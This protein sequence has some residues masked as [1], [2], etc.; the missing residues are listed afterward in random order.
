MGRPKGFIWWWQPKG[1]NVDLLAQV[2]DV[3]DQYDEHLPLTLRQIFYRLVALYA[4]EKTELAYKRL[5]DLLSN[6]RRARV[7]DMDA[8]RDDGFVERDQA[9]F[10]GAEDFLDALPSMVQAAFRLDRQRGQRRRLAVWCEAAGMVPQLERVAD[11]FGVSVLSSGGFDSLT[12]KHRTARSWA[13]N[14]L[15][16]TVLHFGDHDPSG[17]SLFEALREDTTAF[18]D[19][20]DGNVEFERIAVTPDQARALALP[21]APPK[22]TDKRSVFV[23]S[24]TWQLE[25][26]DPG[27]LARLVREAIETRLDLGLYEAVLRE[28]TESRQ[29]VISRLGLSGDASGAGD[30]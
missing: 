14:G 3:L 21:S 27:D 19:A 6:A 13:Q 29:G 20:Y 28:E 30:E 22:P 25:A 4:Y 7:V 12:D 15:P 23:D 26:L 16:V 5:G 1:R 18:A 10:A 11:S 9:V 8:I 24:E 2:E 17:V